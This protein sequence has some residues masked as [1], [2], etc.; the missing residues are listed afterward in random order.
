MKRSAIIICLFLAGAG[1]YSQSPQ[2]F[3]YQ[4]VARDTSGQLLPNQGVSF[5]FSLLQGGLSGTVVY[6]ETHAALTNDFG[7]V[8][9][10]IGTG[11]PISGSFSGIDWSLGPYFIRVELDPSGGGNYLLMGSSQLLSVP[12]ALYAEQANVPGL[13]GPQGVPGPAGADGTTGPAGPQ[14]PKGDKGDTGDTG[15]AGAQGMQGVQG[16]TGATGP[17]GPQG[18]KGDKGDTGDT[19]PAGAQGMQGVQGPT[20]ATGPAGPQG[21]KG[22]KGDTGD[23]GPTGAQGMQGVQG[24]TG[25][26]GPQGP[27]GDKGD[28]GDTGPMGAQGIPGVQGSTGATGPAGPVGPQGP[29]G[30]LVS[31]TSGQTLRHNGGSWEASSLLFNSG[32]ALGV[33]TVSPSA[34]LHT[35]GQNPGEGNVLCEGQFQGFFPG[36]P[37]ASGQGTRMMWYPD[38]AA[39]RVGQVVGS[40]WDFNYIGDN[41]IAMGLN[42]KASGS[43]SVALGDNTHASGSSSTAMGES[44]LAS[45]FRSTAMG[46]SSEASGSY[47]MAVNNST[48]ASGTL[49]FAMGYSTVASAY[50][51]VACG[52][53]NQS[54]SSSSGSWNTSDPLFM[55]GNGTSNSSRSNALTVLKNGRVGIG[56]SNPSAGLHLKSTGY[57]GS[58][59]FLESNSGQDAGFRIY[60]GSTDKWHIFNN[61]ALGGLQIYNTSGV[62]TLFLKQTNANVGIG[63]TTPSYKLQVGNAGDGTTARANAWSLFSDVRYKKDLQV[64]DRPLER[65][66]NIHGYY[67][68]W[69][70][71]TDASRQ[72]GFSAQQLQAV[73]PEVVT[74]GDDGTLSVDYGKMAPLLL[75]ALRELQQRVAVLE[76][77]NEKIEQA[78]DR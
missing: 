74:E 45:G 70:E 12:Y 18:P 76:A 24:P 60:E 16:P 64:I 23:T 6:S 54:T 58:F 19:G 30:P 22:D 9:L 14:G 55:I 50:V 11:S 26:T 15:P 29:A 33:G 21:P 4:A 71:G 2:G 51:S 34:L 73:I 3:A 37:P 13:P 41:S 48:I 63:T 7:L 25:A 32:S 39:F 62:T 1:V 72:V 40:N 44:T 42:T 47:A 35:R 65:I 27:K 43:T 28:T 38:K 67:Y 61:S 57:P 53:Y 66:E 49:S 77:A 78:T 17:A 20:G 8:N 52:Q 10:S 56:P 75:E 36:Y 68:Y 59:M 69:K 46:S 5:R 31:G